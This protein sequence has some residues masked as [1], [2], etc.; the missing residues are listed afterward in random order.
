METGKATDV[1][2]AEAE[3]AHERVGERRRAFAGGA[4]DADDA[5]GGG[6][7]CPQRVQRRG[8]EHETAVALDGE[9]RRGRPVV[10]QEGGEG[11]DGRR[12]A[13]ERGK[14]SGATEEEA[15]ERHD[16]RHEPQGRGG[17]G[18]GGGARSVASREAREV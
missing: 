16:E 2:A 15:E 5:D 17:G 6:R 12:Q 8:L 18:G 9:E 13:A 11:G 4:C 10:G 14:E 3:G 7:F 1:A